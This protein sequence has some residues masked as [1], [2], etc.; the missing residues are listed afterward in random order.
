ME[1]VKEKIVGKKRRKYP[2]YFK[3]RS[4]RTVTFQKSEDEELQKNARYLGI[5]PTTFVR[6]ATVAFMKG[7][8]P[9][10]K[11][12]E[13]EIA[14]IKYFWF[15]TGNSLNQIAKRVNIVKKATVFD[16]M[17][18]KTKLKKLITQFEQSIRTLQT[19]DFQDV[20][21]QDGQL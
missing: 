11:Q 17:E 14:K 10:P 5:K 16:L 19:N 18:A 8:K 7:I 13:S 9:L 1:E 21:P 15:N 3:T 2:E 6:V 4:F 12:V 20:H